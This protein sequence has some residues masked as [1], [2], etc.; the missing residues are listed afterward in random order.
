MKSETS[1]SEHLASVCRDIAVQPMPGD[2]TDKA[3]LCLLDFIA[4][5]LYGARSPMGE[6][7]R[8]VLP[9]MGDGEATLAAQERTASLQGAA[10]FHGLIAT[11]DDLDDSHRFATGIHLSAVTIPAALALAE[12]RK[13]S[14][15]TLLKA[16]AAGY[17]VAGRVSRSVDAGLR[18][19]GWHS[20]GA[21]G[22]FA[23]CA[24]G[25]VILDLGEKTIADGFG[26]AASGAGGLFAFLAEGSSVRHAHGAWASANG[27]AAVML[28]AAGMTGP[29][30]VLEG[31]DG[32]LAAFSAGHDEAFILAPS[33]V[34]AGN[35]EIRNAY[36]KIH[37]CCGHAFPSITAALDLREKIASRLDE[38]E[39]IEA[40][41]YKASASLT[42]PAPHTV[43]EAKFSLPY[44]IG[45]ALVH[46]DVGHRRMSMETIR[47]SR[48][49][50]LAAKVAVKED[51]AIAAAF[52]RLRSAELLIVMKGGEEIRHYVDAPLGMPENPVGWTELEAK[53]RDAADG[54]LGPDRSARLI[55][56]I[57]GIDSAD[58]VEDLAA[59]LRRP[60]GRAAVGGIPLQ[61]A[62]FEG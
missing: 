48:V 54:L 58:T 40:R 28:A 34:A 22:P 37:A 27:L 44:L 49:C 36:H 50:D 38:I 9:L 62:V 31:K 5:L 14:G 13:C 53:F 17:E 41:V 1:F 51:T 56:A 26:I 19:R 15:R 7:G 32:Y 47:D 52:P 6:V 12:E 3:K 4:A 16:I 23:A 8:G 18:A 45:I 25:A 60:H 39:S 33:P 59:F 10:F 30:R 42:N 46:G 35:Y 55:D 43:D 2:V 21:V 24:A 29:R 20:T 61:N 57:R 11:A